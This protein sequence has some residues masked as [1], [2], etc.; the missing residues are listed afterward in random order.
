M[1]R[2]MERVAEPLRVM[3]AQ[4]R[5]HRRADRRLRLAPPGAARD[6]LS[7]A[8]RERPGQ[9]R[10]PARRRSV[11]R[12]RDAVIR[13]GADAR[14]HRTHA[15]RSSA[16]ARR[17]G[18]RPS[19]SQ[20]A[21]ASPRAT[22]RAGRLFVGG[23]LHRRGLSRRERGLTVRRRRHESDAHRAARDPAP[24]GARIRR[25]RPRAA[26][27]SRSRTSPCA[28]RAAGASI[29]PELVPLAIDELPV[30]FVAAACAR[31]R[32][33]DHG[34]RRT[35]RQGERPHCR[36]GRRPA[37]RS[38]R[39]AN[40]ADGMRIEGGRAER[41]RDRQPRRPPGGDVV[42]GRQPACHRADPD[43]TTPKR[44]D[45]VPRL[46]RMLARSASGSTSRLPR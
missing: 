46:R 21:A 22:R 19:P 13:T 26:A 28:E 23:V 34:R 16:C 18:R 45:L 25:E 39:A 24:M 42:R 31:G 1:R 30:L 3:G 33:G 5:R 14:S 32:D 10:D 36:H 35:A 40:S 17:A 41:R 8:G 15:A 6:R 20:A 27:Q 44:R 4:R 9:I 12:R 11:R 37:R 43:S 7:I 2:P 38:V 29:P